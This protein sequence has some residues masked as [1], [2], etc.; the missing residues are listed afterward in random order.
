[1]ALLSQPVLQKVT[2]LQQGTTSNIQSP[3]HIVKGPAG[4]VFLFLTGK[5][6]SAK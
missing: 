3:M 2:G 5:I 4:F 6:V 1:M